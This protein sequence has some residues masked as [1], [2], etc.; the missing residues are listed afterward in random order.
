L[1]RGGELKTIGKL[2]VELWVSEEQ[3]LG[4][5]RDKDGVISGKLL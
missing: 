2:L 5:K 1:W 4:V 3:K